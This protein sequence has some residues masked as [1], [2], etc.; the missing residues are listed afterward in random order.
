MEQCIRHPD[1][2]LLT[3][4]EWA[5]I[6]ATGRLVKAELLN[7]KPDPRNKKRAK[8][9][10]YFRTFHPI[11]WA[12]ALNKMEQQQP[13]LALCSGQWKADHVLGN[14]LLVKSTSKLADVS[15]PLEDNV[16]VSGTEDEVPKKRPN[17]SPGA[18][19]RR[20]KNKSDAGM[21]RYDQ[22]TYMNSHLQIVPGVQ[23]WPHRLF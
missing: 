4:G 23:N 21:C 20:K 10:S 14:T 8:T 13:L 7:L 16:S 15:L 11:E 1:G 18:D 6:R 9:K 2:T 19:R 5:S 3:S 17:R 12:N 22:F